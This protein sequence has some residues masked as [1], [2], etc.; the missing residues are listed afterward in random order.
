VL[1]QLRLSQFHTP[2]LDGV[3]EEQRD[4]LLRDTASLLQAQRGAVDRFRSWH[5][6]A[7]ERSG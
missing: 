7:F 6:F 1:Q 2:S 4:R 3:P 5:C